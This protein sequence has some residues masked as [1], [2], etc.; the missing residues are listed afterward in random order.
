MTFDMNSNQQIIFKKEITSGVKNACIIGINRIGLQLFRRLQ[1]N[2]PKN[3]KLLGFVDAY[4]ESYVDTKELLNINCLGNLKDLP[5]LVKNNKIALIY[6]AI[7]SKDIKLIHKLVGLCQSL[8]VKYELADEIHDIIYGNTISQILRD[9]DRPW[10]FSVRQIFES[11]IALIMLIFF[12]PLWITVSLMIKFDSKGPTLYSQE[13][14][15]SNGRFFRI[16]KFRSMYTDA[17]Q[18]SGPVL[19]TKNDPRIT[20]VGNFLRKTRLDEIPQLMNV[21]IGDMSFIGPRPE[22]PYF[23]EKYAHEIPMYR[24]RLKIKPGLTGYAQ[25]RT[26]YDEDLEDVK[27]KLRHDLFYLDHKHSLKLNLKILFET[28]W[29]VV[30]GKG[31]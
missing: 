25:V 10:E 23:V 6:I 4:S 20:K 15:G 22:R 2:S 3:I 8:G 29:V 18:K 31:Q 26:G 30:T 5:T 19:A 17:E 14:V 1:V 27:N 16:F 13:R 24:N 7:D 9:L 12:L 11:L 21:L 28:F